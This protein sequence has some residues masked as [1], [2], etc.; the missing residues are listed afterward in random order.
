MASSHA[1]A[2]SAVVI[3]WLSVGTADP[4]LG[5]QGYRRASMTHVTISRG[6][7][8]LAGGVF[9]GVFGDRLARFFMPREGGV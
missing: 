9:C 6:L 7:E 8:A 5:A 4:S 1:R 3:Q 2:Q